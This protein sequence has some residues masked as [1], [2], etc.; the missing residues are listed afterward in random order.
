MEDREAS[1]VALV[2]VSIRQ[3]RRL[4]RHGFDSWIRKIPWSMKGQPV[5]VF[6]SGKFHEQN[7][8]K[9]GERDD[10]ADLCPI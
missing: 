9:M 10:K 7:D 8:P 1:E 4:E 6:L 2:A 5:S 3:H